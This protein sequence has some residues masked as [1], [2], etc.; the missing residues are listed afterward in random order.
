M[1]FLPDFSFAFL[2]DGWLNDHQTTLTPSSWVRLFTED[3]KLK[4]AE[5]DQGGK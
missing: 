5:D 1:V 3:L 4:D 2:T